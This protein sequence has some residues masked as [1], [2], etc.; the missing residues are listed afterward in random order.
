[1]DETKK[2][3]IRMPLSIMML[4]GGV[5][6]LIVFPDIIIFG[7]AVALFWVLFPKSLLVAQKQRGGRQIG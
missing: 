5:M 7:L 2:N 3:A 1:M 6:S 4:F